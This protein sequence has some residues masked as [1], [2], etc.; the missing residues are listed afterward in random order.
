MRAERE[1][2]PARLEAGRPYPLGA[3]WDGMGVNFAVF[4]THATR[5][6]LCLF[7]AQGRREAA[8]LDLP[9]KSVDVW[10]G[11][12]PQAQPGLVYGYRAHGPYEPHNGLRFNPHKLLLDPY[13]FVFYTWGIRRELPVGELKNYTAHKDR[14]LGRPAAQRVVDEEKIKL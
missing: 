9:E 13:A 3:S 11:Y 10:H 7:D 12:L 14:M 1:S 2:F 5:M 4:S 8:R 6:Q